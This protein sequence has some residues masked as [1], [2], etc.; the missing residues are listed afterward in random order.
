MGLD[1]AYGLGCSLNGVLLYVSCLRDRET[2][3]RRDVVE[4]VQRGGRGG[5]SARRSAA[6]NLELSANRRLKSLLGLTHP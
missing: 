4:P 2:P 6:V 1:S 5:F 3:L